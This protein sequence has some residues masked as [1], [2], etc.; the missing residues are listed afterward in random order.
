MAE[1][2]LII[3]SNE[4]GDR[5]VRLGPG[6]L[7]IGR[8]TDQDISIPDRKISNAHAVV[9]HR[10]GRW[11][12]RDLGSTN[13]TYVNGLQVAERPLQ[14]DD[15]ILIG[16]TTLIFTEREQV[17]P[18]VARAP[19]DPDISKRDETDGGGY[20]E[21]WEIPTDDRGPKTVKFRLDDVERELLEGSHAEPRGGQAALQRKL[22]ALY[23]LADM[24]REVGQADALVE[25]VLDLVLMVV[26]ADRGFILGYDQTTRAFSPLVSR[27]RRGRED[28][29][30]GLTL[31][32]TL[33]R[34]AVEGD[35]AI[36]TRDAQKDDRFQDGASI[37]LYGIRSAVAVPMRA[38]Q[39]ILGVL[40]VDKQDNRRPLDEEDLKLLVIV[41]Q[42]AASA[43]SN[44]RLFDDLTRTNRDLAAAKEE[45]LRWNAE[46]EQKVE[47]RT[48]E[49][50][51]QGE[52]ISELAHQKDELLGMVAHDLRTP[53]TGLLGFAE[54]AISGLESGAK[55]ERL[56]D[57]LD[58][59]RQTA[60]E[61]NELLS[62]LLDVSKIEAGKIEIEKSPTDMPM[63][64]REL[65]RRYAMWTESKGMSLRVDVEPGL[66]LVPLDVRR[67]SQVLNNL[68]SNGV[69]FSENGDVLTIAVR[70]SGDIAEVSVTD[71]GQGMKPEDVQ[72]L[73]ARFEQASSVATR[74]ERGSGLGLAIARKLVEMHGGKIWVESKKGVGSR[75]AFTLPLR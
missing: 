5:V 34:Q 30:R 35:E 23:S 15:E 12:I 7:S 18:R 61:M 56:R 31:S 25:K 14:L 40:Y 48:E 22:Q 47:E 29:E 51:A 73:F 24:V 38:R 63:L 36:I 17:E 45:I 4:Y 10:E 55:R 67:V 39:G 58:V 59:I 68:V 62:D 26:D 54:I 71:T 53:L 3:R 27:R 50:K 69:K 64:L 46:L 70:R 65:S 43:I 6:A 21:A 37:Y 75:F 52:R 20:G 9:E 44:A 57:D 2:K 1:P 33:V 32:T 60:V 74:G 66:P 8:G 49:I 42:Q 28:Q 41:C 11:L 16:N 19:T 13:G 72:K